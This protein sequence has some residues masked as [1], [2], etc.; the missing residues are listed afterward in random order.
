MGLA[1]KVNSTGRQTVASN[2]DTKSLEYFKAKELIGSDKFPIRLKGFFTQSGKYGESVTVVS[3]DFGINL[4]KRYVDMFK[5]F[6]DEEVE[7]LK[8]GC[9]AIAAISEFDG[10]NGKTVTIDFVDME[11]EDLPFK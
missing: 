6:T 1:N 3:D 11:P 10:N 9:L 4:P 2:I 5:S 8:A 7:Q